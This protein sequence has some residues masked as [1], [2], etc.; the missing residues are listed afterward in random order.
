MKEKPIDQISVDE[1]SKKA[2]ISRRNFYRHFNSV[3]AVLEHIYQ[4]H[5]NFFISNYKKRVPTDFKP[6]LTTCFEHWYYR[7]KQFLYILKDN[8]RLYNYLEHF[9]SQTRDLLS[10][11]FKNPDEKSRYGVYVPAF[12]IGGV[13]GVLIKWL[14][15][16]AA[17]HP[18]D[19]RSIV[20]YIKNSDAF[21][22]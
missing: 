18:R 17:I 20:P 10:E 3:E 13:C 7:D 6:F 8:G 22:Q 2:T 21:K 14:E 9:I 1:L 15:D 12:I 19:M 11:Q 16:G 4:M 5:I